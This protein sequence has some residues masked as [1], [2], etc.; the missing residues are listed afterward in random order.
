VITFSRPSALFSLTLGC[1]VVLLYL[2]GCGKPGYVTDTEELCA[3]FRR[4][5][6]GNK[7]VKWAGDQINSHR[8]PSMD[9]PHEVQITNVPTWFEEID[10]GFLPRGVVVYS[11]NSQNDYVRIAWMTGRGVW[12]LVLGGS[13]CVPDID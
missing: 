9:Q 12:G 2:G 8:D 6:E 11:T 1:I 13:N 7:V 3:K 4:A 5:D 10:P